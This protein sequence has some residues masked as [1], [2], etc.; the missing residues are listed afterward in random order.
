MVAVIPSGEMRQAF[1][2]LTG[3]N[4]A[5]ALGLL[6]SGSQKQTGIRCA[7]AAFSVDQGKATAQPLVFDTDT[8][9]VT[10]RGGFDFASEDLDLTL[11]G[12]SKKFDL[13][14]VRAP[15]TIRGTMGKPSFGLD[16][17]SLAEQGGAAAALGVLATPVAALAAFIDPG[18][19]K[20]QDCAKLMASPPEKAAEQPGPPQLAPV[21]K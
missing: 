14:H 12:K 7:I 21:G 3:I 20:N 11:T 13:V 9:D 8:V 2:E 17:K 1:A 18:L 6:L 4:A 19:A 10:G 16:A 5:R 15:I